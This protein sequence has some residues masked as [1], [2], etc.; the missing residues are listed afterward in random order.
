M[1]NN[2]KFP[3]VGVDANTVPDEADPGNESTWWATSNEKPRKGAASPDSSE[4]KA[5]LTEEMENFRPLPV[6]GRLPWNT[7]YLVAAGLLIVSL[8]ALLYFSLGGSQA[9]NKIPF[10]SHFGVVSSQ[11]KK[12]QSG[13]SLPDFYGNALLAAENAQGELPESLQTEWKKL[14]PALKSLPELSTSAK[15]AQASAKVIRDNLTKSI[16][17]AAPL[18]RQAGESGEWSSVEAVNFAQV[19]SETQF[20]QDVASRV[21]QGDGSIPER[22]A[23]ARQ[24]VEQAFRVYAASPAA[25]QNTPLS[26]AWRALAAGFGPSRQHL[27]SLVGVRAPWNNLQG[28]D[29]SLDR[30]QKVLPL[31]AAPATSGKSSGGILLA[32]L[33][34]VLS[35]VM[36]SWVGW[37]QQRWRVL[38]A[39]SSGEQ[40]RVDIEGMG[41][42]LKDLAKGDLTVHVSSSKVDPVLKPISQMINTTVRNLHKLAGDVKKTAGKTAEAAQRATNA[43]GQLVES[44]QH[45]LQF[46]SENGEDILQLSSAIQGLSELSDE[47]QKLSSNATET[48]EVGK[49]ALMLSRSCALVIKDETEQGEL[50]AQRLQKSIS[51]VLFV[52]T[53]LSEV[54]DQIQVLAIQA[55]IQATRAGDA[56][57]GFRVVADGL[58]LLAEKSSESANRVAS[59]VEATVHD[60]KAMEEIFGVVSKKAE[61]ASQSSDISSESLLMAA[62]NF[63]Q[64]ED[65]V[66]SMKETTNEQ[67]QSAER[68]NHMTLINMEQVEQTSERAKSA[69]IAVG[70]LVEETSLLDQSTHKFKVKE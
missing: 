19:L 56:G 22:T 41:E 29:Q 67:K 66:L 6:V 24:N 68:L 45:H 43:T 35:C 14:V 2:K 5:T 12:A 17:T 16:N 58:K 52:S 36:L 23:T 13:E 9:E 62:Q 53:F 31:P 40:L 3:S 7:Q 33:I 46:A 44:A 65:L 47:A 49:E 50:R 18:W 32:A 4:R 54:S 11:V 15:Q 27:D 21:A 34:M 59:L 57:Q 61:E 70:V 30:I 1:K 60:I 25:S 39:Q 55:A 37:K 64:L 26:Q 28:L 63:E 51:E 20:L 8:L 10:A 69:A 38:E 48:L 42:Q